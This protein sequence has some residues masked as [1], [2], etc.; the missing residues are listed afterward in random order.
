M[1]NIFLVNNFLLK[2]FGNKEKS[3]VYIFVSQ[4]F[5]LIEVFEFF[6]IKTNLI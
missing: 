3:V 5:S 6:L 4:Y 2:V 1:Q